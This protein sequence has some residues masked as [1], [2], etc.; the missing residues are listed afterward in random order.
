MPR[1]FTEEVFPDSSDLSSIK[2][3]GD[4]AF[5]LVK[6]LRAKPGESVTVVSG[7]GRIFDCSYLESL[8]DNAQ[9]SAILKI[10]TVTDPADKKCRVTLVQGMPKGKKTD[11][12]LQKAT[13]LGADR[14]I[15]VYMDH[16]IPVMDGSGEGKLARFRKI[17]EEAAGQSCRNT[18]PEVLILPGL[19]DAIPFLKENETCF[20][21]YEAETRLRL[22]E[23]LGR[24]SSSIGF[25][26]GPEGGIS[27]RELTLLQ[28]AGIP[29]VSLGDRIL[30]TET[31]PLAVL[32]MILYETELKS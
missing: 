28:S 31:A 9:L 4:N 19:S 1:F 27:P 7:D 11:L 12:I 3:V 15:F 22:P 26:I 29:T 10:E 20:A 13:E 16:S 21:C 14:I 6:V 17:C 5:H 23:M 32:S 30:R 18:V 25:L 24:L 2:L 8:G